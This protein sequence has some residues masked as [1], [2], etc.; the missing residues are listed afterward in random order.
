MSNTEGNIVTI[1]PEIWKDVVG[2]GGYYEV[3][4]MGRVRSVDRTVEHQGG[5]KNLR[6]RIRK[7]G[8]DAG[9]YPMVCLYLD[10]KPKPHR[11][12]RLVALAFLGEPVEGRNDVDHING[13]VDDNSV[14]NLR[15]ASR[16][17][18]QLN[19]H[20]IRARSGVTGVYYNADRIKN[21]WSASI[22]I[23]G[24]PTYLG[25]FATIEEATEAR[26]VAHEA[27]LSDA[28]AA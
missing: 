12:H 6:G 5:T 8:P 4:D 22:K 14:E 19:Q 21:P 13:V 26:R 25:S 9:G 24:R 27:A 18:N 7:P 28:L 10:G 2:Y 1:Q 16:S 17:A 20:S 3:S 11:V 15:W 23:D